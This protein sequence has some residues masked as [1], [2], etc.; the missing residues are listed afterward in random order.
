MLV[1]VVFF[2]MVD[3]VVMV[4]AA[5]GVVVFVAGVVGVVGVVVECVVANSE[6]SCLSFFKS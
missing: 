3:V 4:A 1:N 5:A 6:V 2:V